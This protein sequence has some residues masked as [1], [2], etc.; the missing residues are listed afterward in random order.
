MADPVTVSRFFA[1]AWRRQQEEPRRAAGRA[2]VRRL[3]ALGAAVL[4]RLA[5]RAERAERE[6]RRG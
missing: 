4:R 3:S 2:E 5:E 6:D 1:A